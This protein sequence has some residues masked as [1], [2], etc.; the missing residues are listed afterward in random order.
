MTEGDDIPMVRPHRA[1]CEQ[2]D[3]LL[4]LIGALE[5]K[6]I[7]NKSRIENLERGLEVAS[8]MMKRTTAPGVVKAEAPQGSLP[9][10]PPAA[11]PAGEQ[12][13]NKAKI[14][15]TLED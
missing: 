15:V 11:V 13:E 7:E 2:L 14:A 1:V 8:D 10:A 9:S 5:Q 4:I 6:D 12:S 3:N